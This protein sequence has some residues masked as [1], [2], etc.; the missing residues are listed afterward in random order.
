MHSNGTYLEQSEWGKKYPHKYRY[1]I[2]GAKIK[3]VHNK[4]QGYYFIGQNSK[5]QIREISVQK[6]I[7]K[8]Y[9]LFANWCVLL[10]Q[11]EIED[12]FFFVLDE[13]SNDMLQ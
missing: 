12:F 9:R 2:I 13:T 11:S 5:G 4:S 7:R 1:T 8:K 6:L 3:W 10:N